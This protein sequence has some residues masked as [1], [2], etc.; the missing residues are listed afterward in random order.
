MSVD[1]VN[2]VSREQLSSFALGR[3]EL[4][5]PRRGQQIRR[6]VY[7]PGTPCSD[8]FGLTAWT[9]L[10][11]VEHM[12]LVLSGHAAA[13]MPDR[14]EFVIGTGD[15]FSILGGH[16]GWVVGRWAT[17]VYT[18]W[19]QG[20]TPTLLEATDAKIEDSLQTKFGLAREGRPA[21]R[22]KVATA[23][24]GAVPRSWLGAHSWWLFRLESGLNN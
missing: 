20:S 17:S 8:P 3:C 5:I 22:L 6:A 14:T 10:C 15:F 13:T 24:K 1:V 18:S 11:E 7:E 19:E 21:R 23:T 9:P 12:S 2:R 4:D 16:D